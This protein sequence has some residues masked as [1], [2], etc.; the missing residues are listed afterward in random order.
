MIRSLPI[1][2]SLSLIAEKGTQD[3]TMINLFA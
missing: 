2:K 1:K 3:R